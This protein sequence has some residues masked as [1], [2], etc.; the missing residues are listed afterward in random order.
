M[1]HY[2]P[3]K[4]RS[5]VPEIVRDVFDGTSRGSII[6]ALLSFQ[7]H[8]GPEAVLGQTY[9]FRNR[10]FDGN[11]STG[12]ATLEGGTGA[13]FFT[14]I[15]CHKEPKSIKFPIQLRFFHFGPTVRTTR[16]SGGVR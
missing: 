3:W 14:T 10:K 16:T 2:T 11:Q 6:P 13:P 12:W 8:S 7:R 1:L 4:D 15:F 5:R 9:H